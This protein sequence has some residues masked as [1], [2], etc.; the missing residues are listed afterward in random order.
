MRITITMVTCAK[1]SGVQGKK[2]ARRTFCPSPSFREYATEAKK[3][4][5]GRPWTAEEL[6]CLVRDLKPRSSSSST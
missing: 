5:A 3:R 6:I 4:Q 1:C 2:S